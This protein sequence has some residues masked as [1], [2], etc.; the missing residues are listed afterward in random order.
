MSRRIVLLLI[1]LMPLQALAQ[2]GVFMTVEQ[3]LAGQFSTEPQLKSLWISGAQKAQVQEILGRAPALRV[4]YHS[5]GAR[6]AWVLEEIGKEL[7]ITVAVAVEND[8]VV[9]LQVLEFREVRGG[10]VR[11]PGFVR[12]FVDAGITDDFQLDRRIDGITG[13]TLSVRALQKIARLALYYHR[14]VIDPCI[15]HPGDPSC[16]VGTS[17]SASR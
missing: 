4:R 5:D 2:R 17:A 16:G 11:Y 3:F 12:Q 10:E 6:T 7:P 1:L 15:A 13:A 14:Q 8:R 9:A